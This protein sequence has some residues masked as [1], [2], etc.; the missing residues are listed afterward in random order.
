M[1]PK[2][3]LGMRG[4]V[5]SPMTSGVETDSAD[6]AI[7]HNSEKVKFMNAVSIDKIIHN[8]K[9]RNFHLLWLFL[10]FPISYLSS[11]FKIWFMRIYHVVVKVA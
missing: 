8:I 9:I 2:K 4:P 6:D 3:R 5:T 7:G 10:I 1:P 11:L